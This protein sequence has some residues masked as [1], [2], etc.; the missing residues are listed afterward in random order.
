MREPGTHQNP[1]VANEHAQAGQHEEL[2]EL[3]AADV[4]F[5]VAKDGKFVPPQ[6]FAT[7]L[8]K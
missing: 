1:E 3:A 5:I 2:G 7:R 6:R 4:F 8:L